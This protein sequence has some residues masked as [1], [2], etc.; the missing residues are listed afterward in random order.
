MSIL[1]F[2]KQRIDEL[3]QNIDEETGLIHSYVVPNY[4]SNL[5]PG[6][7]HM[8]SH[9]VSFALSIF[10]CKYEKFYPNANEIL[11]KV[12]ACQCR[13]GE[14]TGLWPYY[15]EE[16]LE[17]MVAP[18][19]NMAEFNTYPMAT[20][21]KV[22][23][24]KL[25][26]GMYETLS[27]ACLYAC[28][29][30]RKRN[31]TVLYTNP[32]VMSIYITVLCGELL[33]KQDLIDYGVHKLNKFYL[34]VMNKGSYDEYNCTG[35]SL[36][37]AEMYGL[38]LRYIQNEEV[39]RKV[40]E[41]NDL[42]WTMMG[43]HFHY[44]TGEI[45]GPNFRKYVNF[46][47]KTDQT[48]LQDSVSDDLNL[49]DEK[50]YELNAIVYN[51]QCPDHLKHHF[52]EKNKQVQSM[53]LLSKGFNYPY[54][55]WPLVDT[56]YISGNIAVGTFNM[57][58]AWNQHLPVTAY[59]GSRDKKFCIRWR[60]L[61]DNYDFCCGHAS[62]IQE[63]GAA[64]TITNFHTNRGDTHHDLDPVKNAAIKA[65]DLRIRYQ[66]EANTEGIIDWIPMETTQTGCTL[67]LL[68]TKVVIQFPYA[69]M[70]GETP[71]FEVTKNDTEIFVDMVLYHGEEK[72]IH[73]DQLDC[74][75][76]VSILAVGENE[77]DEP[78]VRK[79][80]EFVIANWNVN[81][82]SAEIRTLL[83]PTKQLPSVLSNELYLD[84]ENLIHLAERL[85]M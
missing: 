6:V 27:E 47:S 21:L 69:E 66:I 68:G 11:R 17:E 84:G 3:A 30:I 9:N 58:D 12:I 23:A 41:L 34:H 25:E 77:Y 75:A 54:L 33:G 19:W 85:S 62:T 28:Q 15:Y 26:E 72:T 20:I 71:R 39:L 22:H 79:E 37:I 76:A 10:A 14:T 16:S 31:L 4:H 49:T 13:T 57:M 70:T 53:R 82:K 38:I 36:L 42:V 43:E 80:Q 48:M 40:G 60:V 81:G 8:F 74:A 64:I 1:E 29:A 45:V 32:V 50:V 24:D 83:K 44:E 63:K 73:L 46:L 65:T 52:L 5:K 59:L 7:Y 2:T 78:V 35:Y 56:Q 61:H 67:D 18:D 55:G 51:L